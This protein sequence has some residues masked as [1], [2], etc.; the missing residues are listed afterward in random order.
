MVGAPILLMALYALWCG[1]VE[2]GLLSA[3]LMMIYL[4]CLMLE[5]DDA[6][7]LPLRRNIHILRIGFWASTI[8]LVGAL[9]YVLGAHLQRQG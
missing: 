4:W 5:A 3:P 8:G 6:P 1:A 2:A 7:G 9:I